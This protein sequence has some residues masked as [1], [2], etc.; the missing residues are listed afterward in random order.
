M[1]LLETEQTMEVIYSTTAEVEKFTTDISPEAIS[2]PVP[3][4]IFNVFTDLGD[5][6]FRGD[7]KHILQ[8]P[9][10]WNVWCLLFIVSV[11]VLIVLVFLSV[12]YGRNLRQRRLQWSTLR[13]N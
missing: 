2:S 11:L 1:V 12:T 10:W 8:L 13:G 6:S 3:R 7:P 9:H 5:T 4:S